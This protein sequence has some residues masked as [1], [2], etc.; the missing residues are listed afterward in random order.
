MGQRTRQAEM[1]VGVVAHMK[2]LVQKGAYRENNRQQKSKCHK[3]GKCR[4]GEGGK[5]ELVSLSVHLFQ[6]E[7]STPPWFAQAASRRQVRTRAR[8]GRLKRG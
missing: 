3:T 4:F 7:S 1:A 5:A 8:I 2:S 6:G